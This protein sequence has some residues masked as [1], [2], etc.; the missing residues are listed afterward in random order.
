[1]QRKGDK[2]MNKQIEINRMR[3]REG[4]SERGTMYFIE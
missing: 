4:E 3:E 1:M 2:V